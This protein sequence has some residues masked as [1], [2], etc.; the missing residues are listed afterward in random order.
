[1]ILMAIYHLFIILVS[2]LCVPSTEAKPYTH[3][4]YHRVLKVRQENET[5]EHKTQVAKSDQPFPT[6]NS[7]VAVTPIPNITS[8]LDISP[9]PTSR[10]LIVFDICTRSESQTVE[11][12]PCNS[13]IPPEPTSTC[14]TVLKGFFAKITVTDCSQLVTFS[15]TDTFVIATVTGA[16]SL[17]SKTSLQARQLSSTVSVVSPSILPTVGPE[18]ST[19]VQ[20]IT[21]YY[22]SPWQAVAADEPH[23]ITVIKCKSNENNVR[24]CSSV[25]QV[26]VAYT[27]YVAVTKMS[28]FS[29]D[30]SFSEVSFTKPT[31]L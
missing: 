30:T 9:A 18:P 4:Q 2:A 12:D 7:T 21:T 19:Y 24:K 5:T 22:V 6:Q 29:V 27:K 1:M 3:E 17:S 20:K 25:K 23:D 16:A 14:S 26:W 31:L 10:D 28:T 15:K 8:S 11:V 13:T